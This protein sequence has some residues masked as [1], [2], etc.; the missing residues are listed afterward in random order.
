MT[1]QRDQALLVSVKMTAEYKDLPGILEANYATSCLLTH[2][3]L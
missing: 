1:L 3:T 2:D